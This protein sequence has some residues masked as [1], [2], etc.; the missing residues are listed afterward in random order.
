MLVIF[1]K[2]WYEH[3]CRTICIL[4]RDSWVYGITSILAKVYERYIFSQP[5]CLARFSPNFDLSFLCFRDYND[6]VL[7][8]GM[9][10]IPEKPLAEAPVTLHLCDLGCVVYVPMLL[11]QNK[12]N[13]VL[14]SSGFCCFPF[15]HIIL[16]GSYNCEGTQAQK[17]S[18]KKRN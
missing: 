17:I 16:G 11:H 12:H 14:P 15:P 10:D 18:T 3:E 5:S 8:N 9:Y 13:C 1:A 7:E 2:Y 6:I 4:Q